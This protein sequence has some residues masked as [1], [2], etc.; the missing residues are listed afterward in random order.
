MV[1]NIFCFHPYLG[2][3]PILANI[4]QKRLK[5]P[6]S[7]IFESFVN[8]RGDIAEG[9]VYFANL[10]SSQDELGHRRDTV[11]GLRNPAKQ[12]IW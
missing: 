2:K 11:D 9:E 10:R 5:P 8:L 1:S 12:L 6:T 4:F 7:I 3:I